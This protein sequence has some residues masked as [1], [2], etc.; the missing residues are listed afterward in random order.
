[1]QRIIGK[2]ENMINHARYQLVHQG[3]HIKCLPCACHYI[4]CAKMEFH[5]FYLN[6]V[7]TLHIIK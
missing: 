4:N 7:T 6:D 2:Q 1:L 5:L 3:C